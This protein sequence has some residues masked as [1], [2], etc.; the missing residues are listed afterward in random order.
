MSY[1]LSKIR[2]VS[3]HAIC[4]WDARYTSRVAIQKYILRRAQVP[5]GLADRWPKALRCSARRSRT[6]L[7]ACA[8]HLQLWKDIARSGQRGVLVLEDDAKLVRDSPPLSS[9]PANAVTLLGGVLRYPGDSRAQTQHRPT[10]KNI[11]ARLRASLLPPPARQL[12]RRTAA[13]ASHWG[14]LDAYESV[15]TRAKRYP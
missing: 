5:R 1:I 6:L 12:G 11:V 3:K 14:I 7:A 9:L 4:D 2:R 15:E 13:V 8:A 10:A